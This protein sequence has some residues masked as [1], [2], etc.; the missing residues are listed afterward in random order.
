MAIN[1][2]RPLRRQNALMNVFT[3]A[4]QSIAEAMLRSSPAPQDT[5]SALGKRP[6]RPSDGEEDSGATTEVDTDSP[7]STAAAT[8]F[9]APSSKLGAPV[10]APADPAGSPLS[11]VLGYASKRLR[12]EQRE[13]VDAF[14][15]AR[16]LP[17]SKRSWL[18]G[19]YLGCAIGA[20]W[21]AICG[22]SLA[23]EEA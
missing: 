5:P 1:T 23:R 3:P 7:S 17:L 14:L 13:E 15:K 16:F 19:W 18:K 4:E 6:Q 20:A 21:E 8:R 11:T 2:T 12:M 10:P 9:E 22:P